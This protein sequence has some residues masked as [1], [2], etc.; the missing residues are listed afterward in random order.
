MDMAWKP[1]F[2]LPQAVSCGFIVTEQSNRPENFKQAVVETWQKGHSS[3][4]S[5]RPYML[6]D[7]IL[8]P[9]AGGE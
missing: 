4:L 8:S 6:S 7:R 5:F 9:G 1:R 2:K 3:G